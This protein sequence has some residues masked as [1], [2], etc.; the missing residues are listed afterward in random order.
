MRAAPGGAPARGRRPRS[1]VWEGTEA[2]T[3]H[4]GGPGL[5]SLGA[6]VAVVQLLLTL[7]FWAMI[8]ADHAGH[9]SALDDEYR[10]TGFCRATHA[11]QGFDSY[12]LSFAVD[13]LG[14][15]VLVLLWWY[16]SIASTATLGP[17]ASI[18]FHGVFHMSQF[19][20]G[21]PLPPHVA[22]VV[23]PYVH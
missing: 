11:S 18:F 2:T 23:Y 15:L 19:V 7:L 21:W 14:C 9:I 5:T 8:A 10:A 20:F 1:R 16:R 6:V 12:Q 4:M 13:M 22:M 3:D 17:A